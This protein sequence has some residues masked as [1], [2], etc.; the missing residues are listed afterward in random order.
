MR[1]IKFN[2][3]YIKIKR[4]ENFVCIVIIGLSTQRRLFNA[5]KHSPE[6]SSETGM[7]LKLF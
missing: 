3:L 5:A 6:T 7:F 4:K 2:Q 1:F